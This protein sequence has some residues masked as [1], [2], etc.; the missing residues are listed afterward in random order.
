MAASI[1]NPADFLDCIVMGDE[2]W[3]SHHTPE[4]KRQSMQWH[5]THSP[6]AK[7][8]IQNL[9]IKLKNHGNHLLGQEVATSCQFFA[10][11]RHH[12]RCCLL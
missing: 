9:T 8:K 6:A 5:H 1:Q 4:N 2:T 12:Q 3:V 11:K 10:L 7:K